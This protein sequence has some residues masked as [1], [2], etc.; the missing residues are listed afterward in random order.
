MFL[1]FLDG[2]QADTSKPGADNS[3]TVA[4]T[5][6]TGNTLHSTLSEEFNEQID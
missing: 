2:I 6:S 4:L 3:D 5:L 1:A